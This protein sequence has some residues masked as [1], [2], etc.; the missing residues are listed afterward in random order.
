MLH[1][2]H[3]VAWLFFLFVFT[4]T[5]L[6]T[7]EEALGCQAIL[8]QDWEQAAHV[9][10]RITIALTGCAIVLG[11]GAGLRGE[12]IPRIELGPIRKFW[13]E[14]T[15]HPGTPHIPLVLAGRFKRQTGERV[16]AQPMAFHSRSGLQYKK[17]LD[18]A[19]AVWDSLGVTIGPLFL[20]H[21]PGKTPR[22]AKMGDV[23]ALFHDVLRSRWCQHRLRHKR[24]FWGKQS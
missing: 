1:Y 3:G 16:Y 13:K 8:E 10:Q 18:R 17:W 23:D 22:Q 6:L 21:A 4:F 5:Q 2:T 9:R 7:I 15:R 11:F 19:I 20:V 14:A 12:E 24:G